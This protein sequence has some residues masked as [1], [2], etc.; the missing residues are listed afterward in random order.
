[1]KFISKVLI[2]ACIVIAVSENA[3]S[4]SSKKASK[5]GSSKKRIINP[6]V[7]P[8]NE[9]FGLALLPRF[10]YNFFQK[11]CL[12]FFY[13]GN[14]GNPNRFLTE[15]QCEKICFPTCL[16]RLKPGPCIAYIPRYYH[17]RITKKCV[18]FIWGGCLPNKNNFT[19]LQ[20]CKKKC[21]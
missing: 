10:Y 7:F 18:K 21:E 1:M 9:G 20:K 17:N 4:N 16:Q 6:C 2:V 5:K 19:S 11:R 3:V 15:D 12:K 13:H 8:K 14:G